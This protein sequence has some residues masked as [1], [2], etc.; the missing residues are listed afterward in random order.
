MSNESDA[1]YVRALT[2]E[3]LEAVYRDPVAEILLGTELIPTPQTDIGEL[4]SLQHVLAS[5]G[6]AYPHSSCLGKCDYTVELH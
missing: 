3:V 6:L 1:K 4:P 2:R 5:E